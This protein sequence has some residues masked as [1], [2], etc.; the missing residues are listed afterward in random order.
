MSKKTFLIQYTEEIPEDMFY[1]VINS[2]K[3]DAKSEEK[4]KEIEEF[5]KYDNNKDFI[6]KY[7]TTITT[8]KLINPSKDLS[9]IDAKFCITVNDNDEIIDD[10]DN[11]DNKNNTDN[12]ENK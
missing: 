9:M 8:L 2:Y 10:N 6:V 5:L 11:K 12:N 4:K 1:M 7:D 3:D